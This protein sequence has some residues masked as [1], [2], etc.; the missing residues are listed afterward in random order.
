MLLE[1]M[2]D[3]VDKR[4]DC[5]KKLKKVICEFPNNRDLAIM[6]A[7]IGKFRMFEYFSE[8]IKND[9]EVIQIAVKSNGGMFDYPLL[10]SRYRDDKKY[11]M[12][13]A[14]YCSFSDLS[15]EMRDD[16]EVVM[17]CMSKYCSG[18]DLRNI[19]NRLLK[20]KDVVM[21]MIKCNWKVMKHL[22]NCFK[23]DRDIA[24]CAVR[25]NG[26][27]LM[28][29]KEEFT[30]DREICMMAV[31]MSGSSLEY[32]P[33]F[34]DDE[35][36]V[37]SAVK[38]CGYAL[39]WA[40]DRLKNNVEIVKVAVLCCSNNVLYAGRELLEDAS[41]VCDLIYQEPYV[42]GHIDYIYRKDVAIMRELVLMESKFLMLADSRI[43]S[44]VMN[45][46]VSFVV[47]E[48]DN[49]CLFMVDSSLRPRGYSSADVLVCLR[50]F[51]GAR[52]I[53]KVKEI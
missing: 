9:D 7:T 18:G 44:E 53:V 3:L 23:N 31:S 13:I 35:E 51:E 4:I 22:P 32:C 41:A 12:K 16:K 42:I 49:R 10:P 48:R 17:L 5:Y 39:K 19:S 33:Y 29:L 1:V 2:F 40:S 30:Q 11:V 8:E 50:V 28:Y 52:L 38:N 24:I 26:C 47:I 34:D 20:D 37:M 43:R 45:A 15:F 14:P 6:V 46:G 36:I 21:S 25:S 27:I